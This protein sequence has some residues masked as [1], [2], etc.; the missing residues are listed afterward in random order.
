MKAAN[1]PRVTAKRPTAK[2]SAMR[3]LAFAFD[4]HLFRVPGAHCEAPGRHDDH[5]WA[6]RALLERL[7]CALPFGR[8][9]LNLGWIAGL[10]R[11]GGADREHRT[12]ASADQPQ[13]ATSAMREGERQRPRLDG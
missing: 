7:T 4:G 11:G 10:R 13:Q 12:Q 6:I 5:L 2:G 1:S 8:A 3:T 9:N